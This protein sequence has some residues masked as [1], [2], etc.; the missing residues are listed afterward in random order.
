MLPGLT[1][2]E[3][4]DL[5]DNKLSGGISVDGVEG[6]CLDAND[7]SYSSMKVEV[8]FGR[9][10]VYEYCHDFCRDITTNETDLV[11]LQTTKREGRIDCECLYNYGTLPK[12]NP[13]YSLDVPV[14]SVKDCN[15]AC[16]DEL[17]NQVCEDAVPEAST[18][19][20]VHTYLAPGYV[21][22]CFY[23]DGFTG[24]TLYNAQADPVYGLD[25]YDEFDVES[26]ENC[27]NACQDE[28][29]NQVCK[30]AVPEASTATLVDLLFD[31]SYGCRCFYDEEFNGTFYS[32]WWWQINGVRINIEDHDYEEGTW[33]RGRING[34]PIYKYD[35]NEGTGPV[36]SV[37]NNEGYRCYPLP[38]VSPSSF[39]LI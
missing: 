3:R 1:H 4:I 32:S 2:L 17:C 29:C 22:S 18:A 35:C 25:V 6:D 7:M 39:D 21:C 15:K 10:S 9:N 34:I 27:N 24:T 5:A 31:F 20:L 28:L 13:V 12:A 36:A 14:E 37:G 8:P 33:W 16:Q 11:G 19:T 23:D 38:R 30:D 26:A